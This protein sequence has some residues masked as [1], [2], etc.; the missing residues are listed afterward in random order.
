MYRN[1]VYLYRREGLKGFCYEVVRLS[2]HCIKVLLK[3]KDNKKKR[4]KKIIKGTKN[5]F[6]FKPKIEYIR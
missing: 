1:D 5:G 2:G 3:S 4:L 6:H